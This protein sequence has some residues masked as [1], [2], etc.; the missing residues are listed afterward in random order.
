MKE[1]KFWG[2]NFVMSGSDCGGIFTWDRKTAKLV[3]LM[4]GD[5]HVVNCI[6]PHPTLPILATSGIDYDIKIWEPTAEESQFDEGVASKLM[7]RN[8]VML[9]ETRD[10]ITVPASFMIRMLACLHTLRNRPVDE[11]EAES[12]GTPRN[13]EQNS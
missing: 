11:D 13:N 2:D 1:A 12:S 9:E 7:E 5:N 4:A 10:I 3:M 6:Q 8:A